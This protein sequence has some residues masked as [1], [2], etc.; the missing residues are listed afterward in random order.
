MSWELPDLDMEEAVAH[1]SAEGK[2]EWELAAVRAMVARLSDECQSL[3]DEN[4]ALK[5]KLEEASN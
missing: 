2:K 1:L 4:E 5:A 3:Y